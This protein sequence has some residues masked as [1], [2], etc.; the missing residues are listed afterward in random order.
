MQEQY[1]NAILVRTSGSLA[2]TVMSDVK[3]ASST[4]LTASRNVSVALRS[5]GH[6][7][8]GP[9]RGGVL[10]LIESDDLSEYLR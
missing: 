7:T 1:Y 4:V 3:L 6:G 10:G 8:N 9:T 2:T 5:E